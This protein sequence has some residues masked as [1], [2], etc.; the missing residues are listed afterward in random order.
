MSSRVDLNPIVI[1]GAS[2]KRDAASRGAAKECSPGRQTG[3]QRAIGNR[4]RAPEGRKSHGKLLH[5]GLAGLLPNSFRAR[6]Q[7]PSATPAG[8][9]CCCRSVPVA[10]RRRR[11]PPANLRHAFSVL[12]VRAGS[13]ETNQTGVGQEAR[14]AGATF[15]RRSAAGVISA[16]GLTRRSNAR[17]RVASH[18]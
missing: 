8:V 6:V 3:G 1:P 13:R 5:P 7:G 14:V 10:A 18:G 15:C 17:M 2:Q 4:R 16:R 11:L 9:D 12:V